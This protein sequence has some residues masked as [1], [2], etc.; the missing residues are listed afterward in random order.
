MGRW[1]FV[2]CFVL[3]AYAVNAQSSVDSWIGYYVDPRILQENGERYHHAMEIFPDGS[4]SHTKVFENKGVQPNLTYQSLPPKLTFI[5]DSIAKHGWITYVRQG[6]VIKAEPNKKD[7][8][9]LLRS[10]NR[11]PKNQPVLFP[12]LPEDIRL[13]GSEFGAYRVSSI[14]VAE[15]I[16]DRTK[17]RLSEKDIRYGW[18]L[19][20]ETL[21]KSI[22]L[23]EELILPTGEILK[24]QK[25]V[26]PTQTHNI[27]RITDGDPTG[28]YHIKVY[29]EDVL[30]KVFVFF[31]YE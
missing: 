9:F 22:N 3:F 4:V 31:V 11:Y 15:K 12:N 17:F 1:L 2:L 10:F 13:T 6:S 24:R 23:N 8:V 20:L 28:I 7:V 5:S 16:D 25:V 29:V 14:G 21:R 30:V 26:P 19:H 18:Q 27:W